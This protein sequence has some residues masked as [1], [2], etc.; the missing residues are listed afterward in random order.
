MK[1]VQPNRVT[2]TY[3]Q[4]LMAPMEAV[5]PLLCPVREAD[6]IPG[7]D[8]SLVVSSCGVA[9][10]DCVFVTA[11]AQGAD[12]IWTVTRHEPHAGFVE[13]LKVTPEVTVCKLTIQLHP[14]AG[15]CK[16]DVT[17]AHTSLGPRGD[18]LV[19]SFTEDHYRRFMQEWEAQLNHYVRHG[20]ALPAQG[21]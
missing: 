3:T 7:W 12:A 13:M 14:T 9:E 10:L 15:G 16:A 8:P 18:E 5:F 1:I 11:S 17:Y 4:H 19:A 6:W 21:G 20:T 2:R